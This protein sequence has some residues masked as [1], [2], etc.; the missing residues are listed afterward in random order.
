MSTAGEGGMLVTRDKKL[1]RRAWSFK[2][3]GKSWQ[4][5][6]SEDHPPGFRW[7]HDEFGSNYR[8]TEIQGGIGRIQLRFLD[9]WVRTR[10][11]NA[12]QLIDGLSSIAALRVPVPT[13]QEFHA[14]YKFMRS[15]IQKR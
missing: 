8:M 15:S 5:V 11:Q 14:Y 2:D 9:D 4:R 10:Q 3:H 13:E 7:L 1:W 12:A 6:H